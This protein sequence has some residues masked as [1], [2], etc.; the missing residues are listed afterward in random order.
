MMDESG[1]TKGWS[2]IGLATGAKSVCLNKHERMN[3]FPSKIAIRKDQMSD[4]LPEAGRNHRHTKKNRREVRD[5]QK[6]TAIL[7]LLQHTP[8]RESGRSSTAKA[9]KANSTK[10]EKDSIK[11]TIGVHVPFGIASGSH[12]L[13]QSFNHSIN[14]SILTR[15]CLPCHAEDTTV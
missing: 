14:Q 2:R 12:S 8:T 6:N 1:R 11:T 13:T 9:T 3:S 4:C 5:R 7:T 10:A 15:Q